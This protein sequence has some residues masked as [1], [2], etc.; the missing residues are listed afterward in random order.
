MSWVRFPVRS[1]N[2]SIDLIFQSHYEP[3][4]DSA[5][6]RNDYQGSSWGVK[7]GRRVRLTNLP[8]SVSRLSRKCGILDVSQTYRPPWPATGIA[9][10]SMYDRVRERLVRL[11]VSKHPPMA[12]LNLIT[13]RFWFS[14]PCFARI[15]TTIRLNTKQKTVSYN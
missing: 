5:S 15:K 8:P 7:V 14:C 9:L 13:S 1:L 12:G 6:N 3:G 2:F 4:V 10:P 11:I